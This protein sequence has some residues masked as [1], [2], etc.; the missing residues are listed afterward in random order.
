MYLVPTKVVPISG[1]KKTDFYKVWEHW[2][3]GKQQIADA[4]T[5]E[6]IDLSDDNVISSLFYS[7]KQ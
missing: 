5:L 7:S 4:S 2:A 1:P 3:K 6:D